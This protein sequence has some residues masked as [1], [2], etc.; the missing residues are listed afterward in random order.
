[1]QNG[2]RQEKDHNG[3]GLAFLLAPCHADSL[4]GI[5]RRNSL[6]SPETITTR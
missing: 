6:P 3:C 4:L 2:V 1:M 5:D